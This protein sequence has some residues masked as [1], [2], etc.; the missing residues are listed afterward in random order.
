MG[1]VKENSGS[2]AKTFDTLVGCAQ[3]IGTVI[4]VIALIVSFLGLFWAITHQETAIQVIGVISGEPTAIPVAATDTPM[5]PTNTPTLRPPTNTPA[6]KPTDTTISTPVPPTST[7]KLTPT[8]TPYPKPTSTPTPRPILV[9]LLWHL[10][11]IVSML[12]GF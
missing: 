8:Y 7:S 11:R 12:I 1:K 3:I 9:S 10:Q 6:P 2:I 5:K 4:G